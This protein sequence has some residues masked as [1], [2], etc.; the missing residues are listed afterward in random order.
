MSIILKNIM[1]YMNNMNNIEDHILILL[2][3]ADDGDSNAMNTLSGYYGKIGDID[4]MLKYYVMAA[5]KRNYYAMSNLS[6]YLK[7]HIPENIE[8]IINNVKILDPYIVRAANIYI[9]EN[10]LP[11]RHSTNV[12]KCCICECIK[13]MA[14][15]KCYHNVCFDCVIR[16]SKCPICMINSKN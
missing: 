16:I 7:N 10:D 11:L 8:L 3:R 15:L 2:S 5:N 4:N 12:D 1:S 14:L 9:V 13:N 6:Y